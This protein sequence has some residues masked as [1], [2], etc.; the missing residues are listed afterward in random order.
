MATTEVLLLQPV[1]NLGHEGEQKSVKA[2]YARNY[3]FPRKIAI[4]V[5]RGNRK[6]MEA[7][8]RRREERLK[9]ELD[10]AKARATRVEEL[11]FVFT[12]KTGQGGKLFGSITNQDLHAK[13]AEAGIEIDR[14]KIQLPEA[15]KSIGQHSAEVK[16]HPEVTA[17]LRFE[18]VSENPIEDPEGEEPAKPEK[19]AAEAPVVESESK[20]G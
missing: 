12:M 11:N 9:H 10:Q 5:T 8:A 15:V 18:V 13:L 2:G 7:L 3:L 20:E 19:P 6:Q 1:E 17:T 16:L 14:H 4:P